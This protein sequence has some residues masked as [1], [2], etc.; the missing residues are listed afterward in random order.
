MNDTIPS[1]TGWA[2]TYG[3]LQEIGSRLQTK[4][5]TVILTTGYGIVRIDKSSHD[6]V[7]E[8]W[9][10]DENPITGSPY[11][12]WPVK[13]NQLQNY[14]R[15]PAR[16]LDKITY[17]LRRAPLVQLINKSSSEIVYTL[18]PGGTEF[19]AMVFSDDPHELRL[20][21]IGSLDWEIVLSE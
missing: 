15:I 21:E 2:I 8:S 18:R 13:A 16:H 9:P 17:D 19:E 6:F 20:K 11:E 12:G 3:N 1:Y 7:L 10:R 4:I 14:G 5:G